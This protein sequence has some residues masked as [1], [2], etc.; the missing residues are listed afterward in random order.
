MRALLNLW[1]PFLG[2]GIRVRAIAADWSYAHVELLPGRLCTN[3]VGTHFGGSLY[4]MTDPFPALLL[5]KQL[6]PEFKVVDQSA[7]IEYLKPG[8]GRVRVETRLPDGEAARLTEAGKDGAKLLPEYPVEVIDEEGD[9]V[10]RVYRTVYVRR[11]R[12][13]GPGAGRSAA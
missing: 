13:A 3:F 7:R 1:P 2:A 8:R 12:A 9:V 11:R 4:A 10:A 6:G 5:Q